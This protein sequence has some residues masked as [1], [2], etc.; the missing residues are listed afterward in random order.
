[1]MVAPTWD[2]MSSPMIGRP[3]PVLADQDEG[4]E[5]DRLERDDHRQQ[6]VRV[7]LDAEP[8]PAAEPD[9]VDVDEP[10]R[11]RERRDPVRDSVLHAHGPLFRVLH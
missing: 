9:D 8:D 11:P 2:L 10:H 3:L 4:R 7:L 1:M 5:E 6:A